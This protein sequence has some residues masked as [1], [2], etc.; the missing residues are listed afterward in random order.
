MRF[1][2]W[3]IDEVNQNLAERFAS[4]TGVQLDVRSFQDAAATGVF[5]AMLYNL[6]FFPPD[7]RKA[8]LA[9]LETKPPSEPVAVHSY[10]LSKRQ[11]AALWRNGAIV[12]RRLGLALFA[13]LR[14]AVA[15]T[16]AEPRASA[17]CPHP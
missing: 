1:A 6:D 10:R 7:R 13:R 4:R 5:D 12:A 16:D 8:L 9:N 14:A 17:S 11:A 3:S 15:R 2:Y